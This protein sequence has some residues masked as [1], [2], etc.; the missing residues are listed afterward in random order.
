MNSRSPWD[1]TATDA[2]DGKLA[3]AAET[4]V[5]RRL[6]VVMLLTAAVLDLTRSLYDP[7]HGHRCAGDAAGHHLPGDRGPDW[8]PGHDTE[9]PRVLDRRATR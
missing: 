5:V 1:I 9:N 3:A 2:D 4:Q 7:R 6:I 8:P